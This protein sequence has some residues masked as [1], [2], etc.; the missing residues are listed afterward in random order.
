MRGPKLLVPEPRGATCLSLLNA[1]FRLFQILES[2]GNVPQ[3]QDSASESGK[4]ENS[5]KACQ[6]DPLLRTVTGLLPQGKRQVSSGEGGGGTEYSEPANL[7][8]SR[9]PYQ[10]AHPAEWGKGAQRHD[11]EAHEY[12]PTSVIYKW[13]APD[14]SS[15]AREPRG[16]LHAHSALDLHLTMSQCVRDKESDITGYICCLHH[17]L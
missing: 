1:T 17:L 13:N 12:F 15:R 16:Q 4:Q 6:Q 2:T 9:W 8:H 5:G 3:K 7:P 10:P 14:T 11:W